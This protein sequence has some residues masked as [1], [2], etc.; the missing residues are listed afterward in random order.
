MKKV[1]KQK[2]SLSN[3]IEKMFKLAS[4]VST[5][6]MHL[7]QTN[8]IIKK[9]KNTTEIIDSFYIERLR[10]Y[11][12]R[13]R[14]MLDDI[15]DQMNLL[16]NKVRFLNAVIKDEIVVRKLNKEELIDELTRMKFAK[17]NENFNYLIN[18]ATYTITKR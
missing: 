6:N 10:L 9:F 17:V 15:Q 16:E 5:S 3:D 8:G 11:G 2:T 13:K 12:E 14:H 1:S 4:K 18:I 7:F